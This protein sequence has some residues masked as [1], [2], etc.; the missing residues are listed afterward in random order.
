[1]AKVLEENL[2]KSCIPYGMDSNSAEFRDSTFNLL[3]TTIF[4]G[5]SDRRRR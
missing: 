5:K 4:S 3:V 2:G 1:M